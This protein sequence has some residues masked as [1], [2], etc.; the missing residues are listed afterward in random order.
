MS[1][2]QEGT[3]FGD[4]IEAFRSAR[5][6]TG[7]AGTILAQGCNQSPKKDWSRK[8]TSSRG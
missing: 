4:A 7:V 3:V 1:G 8:P 2:T 5:A 6:R